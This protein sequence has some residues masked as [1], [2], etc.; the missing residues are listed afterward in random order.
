MD[1]LKLHEVLLAIDLELAV[2]QKTWIAP[3]PCAWSAIAQHLLRNQ[4][5]K[6]PS[7]FTLASNAKSG[8]FRIIR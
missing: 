3:A 8:P 6:S 2:W 4:V 1:A 7:Q 5:R